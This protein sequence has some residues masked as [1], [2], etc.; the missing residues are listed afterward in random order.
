[1]RRREYTT[2]AKPAAAQPAPRIPN[3]ATVR[4]VIAFVIRKG[5][6]S[7]RDVA[8][9]RGAPEPHAQRWLEAGRALGEL[10]LEGGVYVTAA[11]GPRC[12]GPDRGGAE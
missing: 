2:G 1:M 5:R 11:L 3:A 4:K 6:A 8:I 10:R 9:W 7:V 12:S